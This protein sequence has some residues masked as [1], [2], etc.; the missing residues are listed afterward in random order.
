MRKIS[1]NR[2]TFNRIMVWPGYLTK[3]EPEELKQLLDEADAG[4]T[5]SSR[6]RTAELSKY[7]RY[8]ERSFVRVSILFNAR[9][10]ID[11]RVFSRAKILS[12]EVVEEIVAWYLIAMKVLSK[13]K[14]I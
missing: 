7:I 6:D 4:F 9:G 1:Y 12:V 5:A 13:H 3:D 11:F 2:E 14:L 8:K 10:E